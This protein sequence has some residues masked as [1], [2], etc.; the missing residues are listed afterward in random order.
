MHVKTSNKFHFLSVTALIAS[1]C[2]SALLGFLPEQSRAEETLSAA[3]VLDQLSIGPVDPSTWTVGDI[4]TYKVSAG[5][6]GSG[7][8]TKEV[9]KDEGA[10]IWLKQIMKSSGH[11][12]TI[13]KLYRKADGEVLRVIRNGS[14]QDPASTRLSIIKQAETTVTVPAGNFQVLYVSGKTGSGQVELWL[15]PAAI[16][17]DGTAKSIIKGGFYTITSELQ[18]STH[19][20]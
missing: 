7:S 4:A 13:E 8:M 20:R 12:E 19:A 15:N 2:L 3:F 9:V 6:L 18:S 10:A 1:V 11:N 5:M 17:V 14:E 16:G